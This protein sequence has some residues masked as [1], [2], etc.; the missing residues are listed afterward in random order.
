MRPQL[1]LD[2]V[3]GAWASFTFLGRELSARMDPMWLGVDLFLSLLDRPHL[4]LRLLDASSQMRL[5]TADPMGRR[6]V[7][8][9]ETYLDAVGIGL[10]GLARAIHALG[11][12]GYLEVDLLR[13]GLDI[14]Q[15]LDPEGDLSTRRVCLIVEDL[16]LRP[17]T[18][19]GALRMDVQPISKA[20]IAAATVVMQNV[21][22]STYVHEF[23]KSP[24]QIEAEERQLVADAEKRERISR[25]QPGVLDSESS[26]GVDFSDAREESLRALAEL[27]RGFCYE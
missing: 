12:V 24:S 23:L 22:D 16:Q 10:R 7:D 27:E 8:L 5:M 9:L 26:S 6:I 15:W 18:R 25:L 17:E 1:I 13:M 3:P 2:D 19:L 20:G 21:S 14:R 4:V 11:H